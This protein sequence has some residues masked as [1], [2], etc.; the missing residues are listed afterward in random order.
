MEIQPFLDL[1]FGL[2]VFVCYFVSFLK[3]DGD[4]FTYL[5]IYLIEISKNIMSTEKR[6]CGAHRLDHLYQLV[7]CF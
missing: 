2:F 6:T 7:K 3:I 5:I 1:F 4:T